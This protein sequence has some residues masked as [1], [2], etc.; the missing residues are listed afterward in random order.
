[1]TMQAVRQTDLNATRNADARLTRS[2]A[3][4]YLSEMSPTL[5]TMIEDQGEESKKNPTRWHW[6]PCTFGHSEHDHC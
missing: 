3:T 5:D 1:M 6:K 4:R 2:K